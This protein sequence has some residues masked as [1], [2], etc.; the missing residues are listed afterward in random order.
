MLIQRLPIWVSGLL[1]S[2]GADRIW[3]FHCYASKFLWRLSSCEIF[4]MIRWN[5]CWGEKEMPLDTS[6][7]LLNYLILFLNYCNKLLNL[8]VADNLTWNRDSSVDTPQMAVSSLAGHRCAGCVC[9][10]ART[11]GEWVALMKSA[12]SGWHLLFFIGHNTTLF[13]ADILQYFA[14]F[15]ICL[16]NP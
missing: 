9:A 11:S 4:T 3:I 15:F 13:E 1:L 10:R 8:L 12:H 6:L 2:R 7:A 5:I 14:D 16:I